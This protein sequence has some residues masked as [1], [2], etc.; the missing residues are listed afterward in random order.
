MWIDNRDRE[1]GFLISRFDVKKYT[2]LVDFA[3]QP[4][5]T[6]PMV[7]D[8][9]VAV[10]TSDGAKGSISH[11]T[12]AHCSHTFAEDLRDLLGKDNIPVCLSGG[13]GTLGSSIRLANGLVY[14]L[15][16][17]GF[18]VSTSSL[19]SDLFGRYS[20]RAIICADRVQ[21]MRR[22]YGANQLYQPKI[23]YFPEV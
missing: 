10:L 5:C 18:K 2:L 22:A 7:A 11:L 23:I 15:R 14:S 13:M 6:D 12:I 3:R 8:A 19:N 20:R 4:S 1:T 17:V 21:V 9:C 16:R